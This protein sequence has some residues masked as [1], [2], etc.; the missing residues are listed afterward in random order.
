[1]NKKFKLGWQ[2]DYTSIYIQMDS[3]L[4]YKHLHNKRKNQDII[5]Y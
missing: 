4:M 2:E 1:M 5:E 3:S